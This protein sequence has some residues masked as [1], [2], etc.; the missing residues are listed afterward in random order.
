VRRRPEGVG[1]VE[2]R[3]EQH[4]GRA[5]SIFEIQRLGETNRQLDP[6]A[7]FEPPRVDVR[8]RGDGA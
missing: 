2:D 3:R 5:E 6:F 7:R 8:K 1:G 4:R